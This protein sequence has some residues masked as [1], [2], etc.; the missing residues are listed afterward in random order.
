MARS[1]QSGIRTDR[2]CGASAGRRRRGS[3]TG[4][5]SAAGGVLFLGRFRSGPMTTFPLR[6]VVLP[7]LLLPLVA[8]G[9]ATPAKKEPS[10][11]PATLPAPRRLV[12]PKLTGAVAIDGEFTEAVWA[13]AAELAPFEPAAG[14]GRIR[15]ATTVRIWYDEAALYLGW[16]C[17][18]VD[19]QATFTARD[20]KFWEEEVA[21]FFVTRG[22]LARYYELQWNPLGGEFDA[23][24][25]NT[26]DARGVSQG[27]KGD[28]SFTAPGM[29]SAVKV[30]GTV[31]NSADRDH[32]W[33]VEV[34]IPFADLGGPAPR[35]G[36][37][38]RA[39]FYRYN[40]TRDLPVELLS[41]SPPRLPGFHQPVR[42][43]FL[44]F[45][46]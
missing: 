9:A 30:R 43:G 23:I 5:A 18:D 17:A 39:N 24:I 46:K 28:W 45:G 33:Q 32:S 11:D 20:S 19:I 14:T 22:P 6:R 37:V 41:W 38:W 34:R 21:E 40:R 10:P 13:R 27:I 25:D 1:S 29:R 8:A 26:L 31:G 7:V 44:E 15:E 35:P 4:L 16:T 3:E 2:A 42:F 36:E 12:V